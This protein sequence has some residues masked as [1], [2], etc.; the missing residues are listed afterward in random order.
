MYMGYINVPALT[1]SLTALR[2][3]RLTQGT[4]R[5]DKEL[6][7]RFRNASDTNP[8]TPEDRY[9]AVGYARNT[10]GAVLANFESLLRTRLI[11]EYAGRKSAPVV[12][13]QVP[14]VLPLVDC[15]KWA[16]F[17]YLGEH[18]RSHF[19]PIVH[20]N[21]RCWFQPTPNCMK[22]RVF[23]ITTSQT[24]IYKL[25]PLLTSL[26]SVLRISFMEK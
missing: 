25:K 23:T 26:V 20:A 3:R 21:Q 1:I 19:A 15:K 9:K 16:P 8:T 5:Y 12:A 17:S 6:K 18:A 14:V 11:D 13:G 24:K 10:A 7:A 4:N 2:R 22:C